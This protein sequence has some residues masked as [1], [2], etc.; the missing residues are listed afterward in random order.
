MTQR[1]LRRWAPYIYLAPFFTLFALFWLGPIASS[2]WYSFTSWD[3]SGAAP[4]VGLDN[5]RALFA[6]PRFLKALRNTLVFW[7]LYTAIMV[8]MALAAAIVIHATSVRHKGFFRASIF[9]PVTISMAVVAIIFEMVFAR[10]TG[11]LNLLLTGI[12]LP[13]VD[14][15]GNRDVALYSIILVKVWRAFGYYSLILLAGLAAIPKELYEAARVDGASW[16]QGVTRITLPLLRPVLA[17]VMIMSSIWALELFDEPYI[18]TGGGPADATLSI[19]IY[20]YQH[21]FQFMRLGYGSAIAFT[22]TAI[23]VLIAVIQKRLVDRDN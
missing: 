9:L 14:W 1:T 19:T 21:S 8:S 2:F 5:Y 20:L 22:L 23:I 12:G 7:A 18:L 16:W 10:G 6:D 11:L 13:R 4:F 15:L 17:F 3:V